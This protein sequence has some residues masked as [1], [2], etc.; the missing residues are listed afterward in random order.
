MNIKEFFL[1]LAFG[2]VAL[3]IAGVT[4]G[5]VAPSIS[6]GLFWV[7]LGTIA[8]IVLLIGA[9]FFAA[10]EKVVPRWGRLVLIIAL[11]VVAA[12]FGV[13]GP[14]GWLGRVN[15]LAI[16]MAASVIGGLAALVALFWVRR[17][18]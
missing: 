5:W 1:N 7:A 17:Q 9:V 2:V 15:W 6:N 14:L 11:V 3:I 10:N 18:I 13:G 16:G 12:L 8:L 4:L